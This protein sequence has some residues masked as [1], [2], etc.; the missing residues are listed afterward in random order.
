MNSDSEGCS[1]PQKSLNKYLT[2]GRVLRLRPPTHWMQFTLHLSTDVSLCL[3]VCIC[4]CLCMFASVCVC[5]FASAYASLRL[6]LC[7]CMHLHLC[8]Y[9]PACIFMCLPASAWM[10]LHLFVFICIQ[11]IKHPDMFRRKWIFASGRIFC[12]RTFGMCYS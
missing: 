3:C 1:I 12:S 6:H 5:A 9:A 7:V 11:N 4:I 10:H 2:S 8:L